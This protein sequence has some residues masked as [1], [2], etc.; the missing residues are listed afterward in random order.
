MRSATHRT[1][2]PDRIP[3]QA[4]CRPPAGPRTW[5]KLAGRLP[6][7]VTATAGRARSG[8]EPSRREYPMASLKVAHLSPHRDP[9]EPRTFFE[10]MSGAAAGLET[11]VIAPHDRDE[12][13]EG[14]RNLGIPRY[15]NRFER[16][17]V[18]C[19]RCVRRAHA[20][21]PDIYHLHE[22]DLIPW[23]FSCA[24]RVSGSCTM[25][26]KTTRP[27]RSFVPGCR[28]GH[29]GSLR[30]WSAQC[31]LWHE[32]RSPSSSRNATMRGCFRAAS[33]CS[34]TRESRNTPGCSPSSA[35]LRS[36]FALYI[37][38]ASRTAA[39]HAITPGCSNIC[40]PMPRRS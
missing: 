23:G 6:L 12:T 21:R 27:R 25:S 1:S 8:R 38:A 17:T 40:P 35:N 13:R 10:A 36:I 2:R 5:A 34:I 28:I 31:R 15:R 18:T 11:L 14:V 3:R 29:A 32:R 9:F 20:E 4:V 22:P 30:P 26:T 24:S 37:P 33:R 7:R 19:W 39:A 16:V